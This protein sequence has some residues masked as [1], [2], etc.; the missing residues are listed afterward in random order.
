MMRPLSFP[1]EYLSAGV[2]KGSSLTRLAANAIAEWKE[3]VPLP[4]HASRTQRREAMILLARFY[5][6]D[7]CD[8][9][10]VV[11]LHFRAIRQAA[12]W[13]PQPHEPPD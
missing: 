6:I 1:L 7:P 2:G 5:D 8:L 9:V 4:G 13:P 12:I 3:N 11:R 10:Q